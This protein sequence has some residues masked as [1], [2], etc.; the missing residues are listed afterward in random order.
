MTESIFYKAGDRVLL[1]GKEQGGQ[2]WI[3]KKVFASVKRCSIQRVT[4]DRIFEKN[5]GFKF[6]ILEVDLPRRIKLDEPKY[7]GRKSNADTDKRMILTFERIVRVLKFIH[8][9]SLA[10]NAMIKAQ[11]M[12]DLTIRT[13]QRHT[14]A[15]AAEGYLGRVANEQGIACFFVTP[16]AVELLNLTKEPVTDKQVA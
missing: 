1:R 15:L 5:I 10:D 6:L 13:M 16:K 3:V 4:P 12:P 2:I 8:A 9:N 11:V 7:K 14:E